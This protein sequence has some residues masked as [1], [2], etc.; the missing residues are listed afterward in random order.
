MKEDNLGE[1]II[2]TS[3]D[4]CICSHPRSSHDGPN[5]E[6]GHFINEMLGDC[7]CDN[8]QPL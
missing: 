6:C 4:E 3:N 2:D 7:E 5:G 8:F 1:E